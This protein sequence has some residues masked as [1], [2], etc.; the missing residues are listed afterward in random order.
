MD[1]KF[2]KRIR[3]IRNWILI[4][5][6]ILKSSWTNFMSFTLNWSRIAVE[7]SAKD[8]PAWAKCGIAELY[9]VCWVR[10]TCMTWTIRVAL[11]LCVGRLCVLSTFAW[12]A[13]NTCINKHSSHKYAR[14]LQII[15]GHCWYALCI[16]LNV[17]VKILSIWSILHPRT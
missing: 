11:C 5:I 14:L 2:F 7:V 9:I 1:R 16:Q 3:M 10:C 8:S 6:L 4:L 12:S 13:T 17:W 15:F